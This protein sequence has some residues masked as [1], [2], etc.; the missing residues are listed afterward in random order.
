MHGLDKM[1]AKEN[2]SAGAELSDLEIMR[3]ILKTLYGG[4]REELTM[5][6]I[7]RCGGA[8]EVFGASQSEWMRVDGIT[9]RVASFF[10]FIKPLYRQALLRSSPDLRIDSEAALVRYAA[11]YFMNDHTPFEV[12]VY[13]D[14]TNKIISTER[15]FTENLTAEILSGVCKRGAV[16]I[17]LLRFIPHEDDATVE[18]ILDGAENVSRLLQTLGLIDAELVDY[19]EYFPFGFM[20][21]RRALCG[22][23]K[24]IA[25]QAA[26]ANK[27]EK[28]GGLYDGLNEYI[29]K[30]QKRIIENRA[31]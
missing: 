15:L 18:S 11:V 3:Y 21:L 7:D 12:C 4:E 31:R 5:R 24:Y 26:S 30:L 20:S 25:V 23:D 1:A 13:L 17:A 19:I 6:L 2:P 9:E 28:A 14:K 8:A 27:Y 10:A 16:K 29:M 22:N